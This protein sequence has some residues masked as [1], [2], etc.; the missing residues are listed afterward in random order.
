LFSRHLVLHLTFHVLFLWV[1]IL[2]PLR[3]A[4][5]T[6]SR[7]PFL[8]ML[9]L[10]WKNLKLYQVVTL[11]LAPGYSH[12]DFVFSLASF[13]KFTYPCRSLLFQRLKRG[14]LYSF[15]RPSP[16][17]PFWSQGRPSDCLFPS[18][19]SFPPARKEESPLCLCSVF[20]LLFLCDY[21]P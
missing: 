18:L 3:G 1:R 6:L 11:M 14:T 2:G 9:S 20:F 4:P 17:A 10:V 5:V 8:S 12:L 7:F 15:L 21:C 13:L 19:D 16:G